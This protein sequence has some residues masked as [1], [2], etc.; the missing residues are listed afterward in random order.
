MLLGNCPVR[1]LKGIYNFLNFII[2]S[3]LTAV[4]KNGTLTAGYVYDTNGNRLAKIAGADTTRG[5]YDAQDR[6][7]Q[8]GNEYYTYNKNGYLTK[9]IAVAD[10]TLYA[11]DNL[12]N[13]KQVKLPNGTL[14]DYVV[15]ANNRRIAKKVNNVIVSKWIYSGELTPIAENIITRGYYG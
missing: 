13:L 8:Y 15:D 14:I 10:T 9:K 11:Y 1:S 7:T 3:P 6:L 12:G 2:E 5:W 4:N